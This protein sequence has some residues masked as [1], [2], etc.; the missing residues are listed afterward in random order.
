[1]SQ[2]FKNMKIDE[3]TTYIRRCP[4]EHLVVSAANLGRER[5]DLM[6]TPHIQTIL[7]Q[8][9]SQKCLRELEA[10]DNISADMS[11]ILQSLPMIEEQLVH[12]CLDERASA[13]ARVKA[14]VILSRAVFFTDK[15]VFSKLVHSSNQVVQDAVIQARKSMH[16]KSTTPT[17]SVKIV[18]CSQKW[19]DMSPIEG[20]DKQRTCLECGQAVIVVR[21][22]QEIAKMVGKGCVMYDPTDPHDIQE[23]VSEPATINPISQP[24]DSKQTEN[25]MLEFVSLDPEEEDPTHLAGFVLPPKKSFTEDPTDQLDTSPPPPP[26]PFTRK[27]I[28]QYS[29]AQDQRGR[30]PHVNE[31]FRLAGVP[32]EQP[33]LHFK[34]PNKTAY[35][36]VLIVIGILF[37]LIFCGLAL[38][39]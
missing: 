39:F 18:P 37:G 36:K 34:S 25:G 33:P 3:A 7:W 2:Q 1:M 21:S 23:I 4:Q 19:S 16:T 29:T 10:L 35:V 32:I 13:P 15:T 31:G 26:P 20:T 22:A 17:K 12:L 11:I 6:Q 9:L 24:S 30:I 14:I 8:R 5:P 38:Y 28:G 27:T